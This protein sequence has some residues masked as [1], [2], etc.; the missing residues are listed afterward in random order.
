MF[1]VAVVGA[2]GMGRTHLNNLRKMPNVR[3]D[4]ICDP[5]PAVAELAKEIQA[6]Y[7]SVLED[8]LQ[9][10]KAEVVL[11]F[12][13]TFL[14]T[15]QI[16]AVLQSGRHCISEKPLCLSSADAKRL[17]AL[18]DEKGCYLYVA[19]VLHFFPEYAKL[20]EIVD[21]GKYGKVVDAFFCRL[22]E[23]PKWLTGNWLFDPAK[24]GLIPYD[25]HIHDLD[26]VVGLFGK[27]KKA[28]HQTPAVASAQQEH[29]RFLYEYDDST[30][31]VEASWYNAAIPFTAGFRVYFENAV[32]ILDQGVVTVY[33]A[34][35]EKGEVVYEP[36]PVA[37]DGTEINIASALP[38]RAEVEHFLQCMEENRKSDIVKEENVIAVLETLEA[39]QEV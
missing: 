15:Q 31:C 9:T 39:L 2:G 35:A 34:G 13:P 36:V 18:A 32:V 10:T 24:S 23:K 27:P 11:V 19:Q 5:N 14:H 20:Q 38:Y 37:D 33:E 4:S 28:Y 22:S 16:E 17:F 8:M 26:M 29:Y 3:I 1:T 6:S 7:H 25:L 21:S 12:T 30:V